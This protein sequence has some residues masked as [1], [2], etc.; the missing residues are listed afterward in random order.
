MALRRR[1]G[2]FSDAGAIEVL[3]KTRARLRIP[4]PV[5]ETTLE[6][7]DDPNDRR[8]TE[9]VVDRELARAFL[10]LSIMLESVVALE[11]RLLETGYKAGG[12]LP[13]L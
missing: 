4:T 5:A 11:T 9:T 12:I 6:A 10:A 13:E 3:L 2:P 7:R 8:L 1:R